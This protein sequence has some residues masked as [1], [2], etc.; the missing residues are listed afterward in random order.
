MRNYR[1]HPEK[2]VTEARVERIRELR[3]KGVSYNKIAHEI[4]ISAQ[5]VERLAKRRGIMIGGARPAIPLHETT[6]PAT[7]SPE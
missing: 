4:G 1:T 6:P 7:R 2:A 5:A 3:T